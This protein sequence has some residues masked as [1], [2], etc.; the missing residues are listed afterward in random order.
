MSCNLLSLIL[1]NDFIEE[2]MST[3]Y[4]IASEDSG[5]VSTY[6][7]PSEADTSHPNAL[8]RF[9]ELQ[10]E[11]HFWN[12]RLFRSCRNGYLAIEDFQFI[13]SQYYLYS[14][15]FTRYISAL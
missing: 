2:I 15:S 14:K 11:H 3:N 4:T 6:S 12:N 8:S 1:I 5:V 9:H 10:S 7:G 13:F